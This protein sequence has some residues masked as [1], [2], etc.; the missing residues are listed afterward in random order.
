MEHTEIIIYLVMGIGYL[1]LQGI[2]GKLKRK[3]TENTEDDESHTPTAAPPA[4]KPILSWDDLWKEFDPN[5]TSQKHKETITTSSSP[6]EPGAVNNYKLKKPYRSVAAPLKKDFISPAK[7]F[8]K[9]IMKKQAH[10]ALQ[11]KRKKIDRLTRHYQG[12][13]KA[14]VMSE[15]IYPKYF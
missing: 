5:A 9:T 12:L 7:G 2:G 13:K 11:L 10:K 6:T 15:L 4:S 8:T 14:I 3:H 1:L